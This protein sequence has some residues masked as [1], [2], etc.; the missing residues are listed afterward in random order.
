MLKSWYS[1][2]RGEYHTQRRETTIEIIEQVH[3]NVSEKREWKD[4]KTSKE[5]LKT[6]KEYEI[7]P[8]SNQQRRKYTSQRQNDKGEC[9]TSRKG[10]AEVFGEF[11]KRFSDDNE[12]DDSEQELGHADNYSST[13]VHNNNIGEMAGI[14]DIKTEELQPAI[15][16]L[17][18]GK[19][20]DS[21]GIRAEDVE[22][23]DE[24]TREMVRQIFNEII[25]RK[26]IHAWRLEE[27]DDK[28]DT[29]GRRRGKCE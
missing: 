1:S 26:W 16:K 8:E 22:A 24:E 17:R 18:K 9:I 21:K 10:I 12:K 19:S 23:C 15:N 20:P 27:S 6:S 14:P 28:S 29:Q 25:K 2:R 7:S 3:E 5:F 13:N 4:S 11:N